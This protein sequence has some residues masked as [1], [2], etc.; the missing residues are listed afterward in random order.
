[1]ALRSLIVAKTPRLTRKYPC[2]AA[3]HA[4]AGSQGL[5]DRCFVPNAHPAEPSPLRIAFVAEAPGKTERTAPL[6][7]SAG[8]FLDDALDEESDGELR[9]GACY[10]GNVFRVRPIGTERNPYDPSCFFIR[11]KHRKPGDRIAEDL[12]TAPCGLLKSGFRPDLDA[13]LQDLKEWKPKVIVTL[14]RTAAWAVLG[15]M[16]SIARWGSAARPL[17]GLAEAAVIVNYHPSFIADPRR[18]RKFEAVFRQ[19]LRTALEMARS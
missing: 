18:G 12:P 19:R 10:R 2:F 1:M 11:K 7:G 9:L 14:G 3:F 17:A 16:P 15:R 4:L 6:T 8:Q 5:V 13:L